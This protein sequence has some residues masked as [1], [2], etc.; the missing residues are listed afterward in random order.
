MDLGLEFGREIRMVGFDYERLPRIARRPMG[1]IAQS[2]QQIGEAAA[3]SLL[4]QMNGEA[5]AEVI[6][7]PTQYAEWTMETILQTR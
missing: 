7:I 5:H 3:Q 4:K 6:R 2:I 1:I